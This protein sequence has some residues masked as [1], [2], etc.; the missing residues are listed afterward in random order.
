MLPDLIMLCSYFWELFLTSK[1]NFKG[2]ALNLASF[3][4]VGF[5]R[6]DFQSFR[7]CLLKKES[8]TIEMLVLGTKYVIAVCT[9]AQN[10]LYLSLT[11]IRP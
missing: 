2:A 5:L 1:L 6:D 10:L 3:S 11:E 4:S 9:M 8:L 7:F